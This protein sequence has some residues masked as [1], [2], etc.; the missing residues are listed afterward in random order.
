MNSVLIIDVGFVLS[1]ESIF[2]IESTFNL[3]ITPVQNEDIK[4]ELMVG[5]Y[6]GHELP[7][8]AYLIQG[9]YY[10]IVEFMTITR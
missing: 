10:D 7:E 3:K 4:E 6:G 2:E 1:T 8:F 5:L 9:K